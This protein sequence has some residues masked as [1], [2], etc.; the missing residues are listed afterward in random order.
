MVPGSYGFTASAVWPPPRISTPSGS[1]YRQLLPQLD[2]PAIKRVLG[3]WVQATTAAPSDEPLALD[4]RALRGARSGE[5]TAPHLLV[6]CT[7]HS[8]ETFFQEVDYLITPSRP[9]K[10]VPHPCSIPTE[11][12][13]ASRTAPILCAMSRRS[14]MNWRISGGRLRAVS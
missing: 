11:A 13:G 1:L 2:V 5:Q 4:G 14:T 12:I 6:F 3:T 10:R 8:Q 7:H 9:A